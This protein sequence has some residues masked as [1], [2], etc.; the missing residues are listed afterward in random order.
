MFCPENVLIY[1]NVLS[2]Y[3]IN[4]IQG[5]TFKSLSNMLSRL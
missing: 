1:N 2:S 5:W 4:Q 3:H